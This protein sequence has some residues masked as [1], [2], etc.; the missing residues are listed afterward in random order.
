M[1]GWTAKNKAI[2]ADP[3]APG[4]GHQPQDGMNFQ[5]GAAGDVDQRVASQSDAQRAQSLRKLK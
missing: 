4:T 2:L 5:P 1:K 3:S